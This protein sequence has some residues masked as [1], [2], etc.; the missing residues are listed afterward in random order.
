MK[1]YVIGIG[2]IGGSMALE[3]KELF[4][5]CHVVGVDQSEAH[6]EEA[7]ALGIIDEKGSLETLAEADRVILSIPVKESLRLLP[8]LLDQLNDEALLWDVGSTKAQLCKGVE[9]HSKR[10]QYLAAHHIAGTE[11]SGPK[12]AHLGLFKG[13]P[14]ILCEAKKTRA[15]LLIWSKTTFRQMGMYLRFMEPKEH[16]RHMACV[17]HLSHISS[18][19]LGKTVLEQEAD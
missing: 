15:D 9:N 13:K 19:M 8:T 17:S 12:A 4:R 11:F 3:L 16:D 1:I 2:L 10:D 5:D 14:Q 7:L 18:F 6:L